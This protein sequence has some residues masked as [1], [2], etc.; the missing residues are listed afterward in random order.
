MFCAGISQGGGSERGRKREKDSDGRKEREGCGK[1]EGLKDAGR[2]GGER[3][4]GRE[5]DKERERERGGG[6]GRA[7]D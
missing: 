6:G 7:T 1:K 3:R 2:E 4:G 5:K